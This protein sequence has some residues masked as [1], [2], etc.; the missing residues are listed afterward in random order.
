MHPD[1]VADE[2]VAIHLAICPRRPLQA[3]PDYRPAQALLP[4]GEQMHTRPRWMRKMDCRIE[5]TT[6]QHEGLHAF[7]NMYGNVWMLM[8]KAF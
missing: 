4:A 2:G 7:G 8:L 6:R 1:F 5:T 3:A